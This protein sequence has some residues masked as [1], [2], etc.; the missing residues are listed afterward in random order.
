MAVR[1]AKI[2]ARPFSDQCMPEHLSRWAMRILQAA[3]QQELNPPPAS[4]SAFGRV[5]GADEV[6]D[7]DNVLGGVVEVDDADSLGEVDA[8]EFPSPGGTV[9]EEDGFGGISSAFPLLER[10]LSRTRKE[11]PYSKRPAFAI[12]NAVCC[13]IKRNAD[14]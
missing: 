2:L 10:N 11:N 7:G 14:P 8:L 12:V 4:L 3:S 9:R 1:K 13:S 6:E 5:A